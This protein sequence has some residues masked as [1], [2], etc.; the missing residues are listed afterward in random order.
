MTRTVWRRMP[1]LLMVLILTLV[2]E[3]AG[4]PGTADPDAPPAG[5]TADAWQ[6]IRAAVERDRYAVQAN[7]DGALEAVNP[8]QAYRTRFT[9]EG[10]TVQPRGAGFE[11]GLRLERWGYGEAL[12]AVP[13]AEPVAAGERVTYVRGGLEESYVNRPTGL[14]LGFT[15]AAAPRRT[16]GKDATGSLRLEMSVSETAGEAAADTILF[17]DGGALTQLSSGGLVARDA[18]GRELPTGMRLV[19]QRLILEVDDHAAVYPLTLDPVILGHVDSESEQA[20]LTPSDGAAGDQFGRSVAVSGDTVVVGAFL[21]DD[22]DTNSGSAYVFV[23][24]AVGWGL[25]PLSGSAKLTASD[26]AA[27]DVFGVTVAISG[28]TVVVGASGDDD[29][30]SSS[31]SAYVFVKPAGGWTGDLTEDAKLTAS[32]GAADDLLGFSVAVSGD[33]VVVG[34]FSD[35][36]DDKGSNSGSA[37]VF[38]EPGGGWTGGLAEGAKLTASDGAAG[39]SFGTSV[40]VSDDTVVV[41]ANRD[42][43]GDAAFANFGSAYVFVKP[44]G[45]W[46]ESLT[47]DAKL[48][49][50]D[51]AHLDEF[52]RSV[53]IFGDSVIVGARLGDGNGAAADAGSAY[54][55]VKPSGGWTG[56]LDE[57]DEAKLT[58]SNGADD[59]RFGRWV[60][61]SGDTVVVGA[62][63]NDEN[64]ADAGSAYVFQGGAVTVSLAGSG[65]G[66]VTTDPAG[67]D[68]GSNCS[69]TYT[70]GTFITL[71]AAPA[72]GSI[73]GG[74]G[75]ACSGVETDTCA[76]R[77]IETN[78]VTAIFT[79]TTRTLT[80]S[81]A[82]SGSGAVTSNPAGID[83]GSEC[84]EA[85]TYGTPVTLTASPAAGSIFG[86]WAGAC[87]GTGTCEVT[88]TEARSVTATFTITTRTLT[89]SRTG[90]GSGTVTSNP[91]GIDC[92][93]ECAEAYIFGT[94]VTLTASPAA[95]STFGGWGGACSG[96]GTCEVTMTEAR[97]VTVTFSLIGTLQFSSAAYRVT[98]P[99]G[100][101]LVTIT[102]TDGSAGAIAVTVAT[103]DGTATAGADY[104]ATTV[105]VSWA[106][107]E[108]ASKTVTVDILDDEVLE[109]DETVHLTLSTPTGGATLGT[110]SEADLTILDDGAVV[111]GLGPGGG[112]WMDEVSLS[113]PHA[114]RDWFGVPWNA[115]NTANGETRPVFCNLDGEGSHELVVGLGPGGG[116][117]VEVRAG[118]DGNFAHQAW[119]GVPFGTYNTANGETRPACGDLDGDGRDEIVIGLGPG[120]RGILEIRDDVLANFAHLAWIQVPWAAYDDANG[121]TFPAVGD[122]DGDGLAEI[123]IGLGVEVKHVVH[124]AAL[125]SRDDGG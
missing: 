65:S 22:K 122:L 42:D 43:D 64:G 82:G 28:D 96:T 93:S 33:T 73:F 7:P 115:Y 120:A 86:G 30:G 19:E 52:G 69:E 68:C 123:V 45:G 26:G 79:I 12:E 102:R 106:D 91:A 8:A 29:D 125:C 11:L 50:G 15:V 51:G 109:V 67:I 71:T 72:A 70:F 3:P 103:S 60:A 124:Q 112:G 76:G 18:T 61:I 99:S 24:P 59:D 37:Y 34:A 14:E 97:S 44:G 116:G 47:E 35:D 111:I 84:S 39:D 110:P 98:E 25:G 16:D 58:A 55:F 32:D 95:G 101:T 20:K 85:Y 117:W 90:S 118:L 2:A 80:G 89:V 10:I 63:R 100:S 66:T 17:N 9:A 107:G 31:G 40:A 38:V 74:W 75:G 13:T 92:G 87:S 53:A 114:R 104:T 119:T 113:P 62:T 78:D 108:T 1:V 77:L 121:E 46:T 27:G 88:M 57:K 4:G 23:E 41:G 54:L 105:T 6:A 49:A 36:D 56:N 5:L 83:C 48:R 21:D 94:T 81:R